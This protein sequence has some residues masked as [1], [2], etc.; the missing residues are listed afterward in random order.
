MVTW[1][2]RAAKS[3]AMSR[4]G[5][6]WPCAIRGKKRTWRWWVVSVVMVIV[7]GDSFGLRLERWRRKQSMEKR[8]YRVEK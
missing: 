8:F 5:N 7:N 4:V 3:L 1:T 6:M 2:F